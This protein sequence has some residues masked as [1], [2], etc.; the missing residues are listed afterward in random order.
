MSPRQVTEMNARHDL[1]FDLAAFVASVAKS[2]PE[3]RSIWLVGSRGNGT[4]RPDSDW[5]L[6]AFGAEETFQNLQAALHLHRK[7]VDFLIVTSGTRFR[8]AWGASGKAGDLIEWEWSEVS[9][10]LATYTETK[11]IERE[12]GSGWLSKQRRG[13]R[14]WPIF[15]APQSI[16]P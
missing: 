7:D 14:V 5:D 10:N 9:E 3:I 13:T 6:I 8:A 1:T 11:W 16:S 2:A 15:N 12:D 4:A